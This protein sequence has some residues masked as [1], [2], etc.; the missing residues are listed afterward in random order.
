MLENRRGDFFWLT[1][2]IHIIQSTDGIEG[3]HYCWYEIAPVCDITS[4][5][6]LQCTWQLPSWTLRCC[7]LWH[8]AF[9]FNINTIN[10]VLYDIWC[11]LL[12]LLLCQGSNRVFRTFNVQP[13]WILYLSEHLC[14][15]T[16]SNYTTPVILV[17][18]SEFFVNYI[19]IP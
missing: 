8:M 6:W 4:P 19:H 10:L 13:F 11:L 3:K 16:F 9:C 12:I 1:L 15:S 2:Y 18:F 7:G 17:F 5:V 14:C